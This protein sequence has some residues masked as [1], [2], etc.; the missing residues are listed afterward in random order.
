M[1]TLHDTVDANDTR[2]VNA[3]DITLDQGESFKKNGFLKIN[4]LFSPACIQALREAALLNIRS[5]SDLD[6]KYG[7]GFKRLTYG[8][9]QTT[10]LRHIYTANSFRKA[11]VGLI[12]DPLIVSEGLAFELSKGETGFTWHYDSLSF[13]FIR[14]VDPG[15]SIWVPLNRI[16]PDRGGGMAY[17]PESLLSGLFNFQLSSLLSKKM[18]KGGDISVM[19]S[20]LQKIFSTSSLLEEVFEENKLE[21]EFD[22]GD[23][24]LFTKSVW[25]R[26]TPLKKSGPESRLAIAIRLL[27]WRSRLDRGMFEGETDSGGGMGMGVNWGKPKQTFYG[28]QFV[29]VADGDELRKSRFCGPII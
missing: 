16:D 21:D 11:V 15:Y 3:V 17:I 8:L 14:P 29:D 6:T 1:S 25:H 22:L 9:G 13:R 12:G 19:S 10:A 18:R 5:A 27:D 4:G 24:L 23:A 7:S 2:F 26:T 28:S 20:P